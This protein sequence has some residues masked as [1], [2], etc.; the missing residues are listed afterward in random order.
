MY[1]Q[2]IALN[3]IR[4]LHLS[5]WIQCFILVHTKKISR[6]YL[7]IQYVNHPSSVI[8]RNI[9]YIISYITL[10]IIY[11]LIIYK[12]IK[13]FIKIDERSIY[14]K[15]L[16]LIKLM[17]INF[18]QILFWNF[19]TISNTIINFQFN[20]IQANLNNVHLYSPLIC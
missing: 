3:T 14:M 1:R 4:F 19:H 20:Q 10:L 6:N 2:S 17:Q 9:C 12:N 16:I 13:T 5:Q 8:C 11:T 15:Y 18:V 7:C